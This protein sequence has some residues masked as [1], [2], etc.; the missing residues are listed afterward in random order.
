MARPEQIAIVRHVTN[1]ELD[2]RIKKL[3][4][5]TKVLQRL[6]FVKHR[7]AGKSVE[8]ASELVGITKNNG[9]IWQRRW[10][11]KG[12]KGL[13]PRYAG[14]KPS[15]LDESQKTR[16]RELIA[17]RDDWTTK[18]VRD[19]I[20]DEFGVEYSLKQVRVILRKMGARYGKPFQ[21]DHRRPDDAEEI[22]KKNHGHR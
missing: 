3:E 2:A 17:K 5:D 7:Y 19:L 15:K 4:K 9:Y 11:K 21:R 20:R 8:A 10:N 14:G 1:E 13:I 22:L 16:L 12:Y 6:Y 18:E